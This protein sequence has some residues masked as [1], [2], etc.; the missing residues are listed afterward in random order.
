MNVSEQIAEL[1]KCLTLIGKN[2]A[3]YAVVLT[4]TQ[5]TEFVRSLPRGDA[6]DVVRDCDGIYLHSQVS[7]LTLIPMA[8]I[9]KFIENFPHPLG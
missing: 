6:L 8:D 7:D 4:P 5:E 1:R 9:G 3:D 2:P